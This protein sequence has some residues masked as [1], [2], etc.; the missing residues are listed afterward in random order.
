M[1]SSQYALSQHGV[2]TASRKSRLSIGQIKEGSV[3]LRS[4]MSA[5]VSPFGRETCFCQAALSGW[6]SLVSDN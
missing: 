2:L 1:H 5:S 4:R 3:G 6:W